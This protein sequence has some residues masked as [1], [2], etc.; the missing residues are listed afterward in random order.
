MDR[1]SNVVTHGAPV[2]VTGG[3]GFIGSHLAEVL[4]EAGAQVTV[5][6][7]LATGA[8]GNL[9]G[10]GSQ[11]RLIVGD[12]GELLRLKR[13]HVSDYACIFHLAGNPYI[14]PSVENPAY[15]LRENLLNTFNLLETIREASE[16]PKLISASSA[17]VYGN[18]VRLPISETDPTVPI[19]PYGVSKLAGERY[20]A[21]YSQL[22]DIPAVSMRF[23]SVY[24]PRQKKQVVYDLLRK[25]EANPNDIEVYGD[26]TQT[27]DFAYVNDVARALLLAAERAPGRGE[28][29]NVASGA[30]YSI[31]QLVTTLCE[32]CGVTPRIHYTGSVRP[33]DA[34]RWEVDMQ[35]LTELGF[36]PQTSLHAG[37]A[38]I[39]DWYDGLEG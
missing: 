11:I 25:I 36:V 37:L 12:V 15:D 32:V 2:L 6:D 20:L 26:G 14:P 21:V 18:P 16:R 30:T 34:D 33:G 39:K 5:V 22:Y 4:V 27:R 35:R 13:L 19:S 3:A 29:Y 10:L 7:N 31:G 38:A 28:A 17:A 23:F 8:T 24:G 9:A 1:D